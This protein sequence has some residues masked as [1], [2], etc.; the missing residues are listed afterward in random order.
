M[1]IEVQE[2]CK[3]ILVYQLIVL[4]NLKDF[5]YRFEVLEFGPH[6]LVHLDPDLLLNLDPL[7]LLDQLNIMLL[8]E[9]VT[10]VTGLPDT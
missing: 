3:Y 5:T 10:L 4:R 2:V 9:V 7:L 8:G 1:A 6:E